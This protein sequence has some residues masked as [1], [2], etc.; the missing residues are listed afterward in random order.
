M[1]I[2]LPT[3]TESGEPIQTANTRVQNKYL[4]AKRI[5]RVVFQFNFVPGCR[6]VQLSI[7]GGGFAHPRK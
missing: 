4:A 3:V 2:A 7:Q 1:K 6:E 5:E